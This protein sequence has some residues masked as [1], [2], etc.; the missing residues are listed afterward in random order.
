MGS[1]VHGA[2]GGFWGEFGPYYGSPTT[3]KQHICTRL[4]PKAA[5]SDTKCC[6][7][8]N[9]ALLGWAMGGEAAFGV[10][11]GEYAA[12]GVRAMP[13]AL[14]VGPATPS[15]R[16]LGPAVFETRPVMLG[17][18]ALSGLSWGAGM[19]GSPGNK[20]SFDYISRYD[21]RASLSAP[22]RGRGMF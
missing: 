20:S 11:G 1:M 6:E 17:G 2:T 15:T 16:L 9:I 8:E 14:F 18:G 21:E 5:Y 12:C 13:I 10:A 3:Q 4:T 19:H 7:V 22:F